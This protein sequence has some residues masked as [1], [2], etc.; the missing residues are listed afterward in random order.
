MAPRRLSSERQSHHQETSPMA[1]FLVAGDKGG[2][3][4]TT[5][6]LLLSFGLG[7]QDRNVLWLQQLDWEILE[8][9]FRGQPLPFR[10]ARPQIGDHETWLANTL[11]ATD[12]EGIDAVVDLPRDLE[13]DGRLIARTDLVLIPVRPGLM[14]RDIA[15]L[16]W[17]RYACLLGSAS[18]TRRCRLWLLPVAWPEGTDAV[19]SVRRWAGR[20][21]AQ[22]SAREPL[23][24]A[25]LLPD[26]VPWAIP[27]LP[28]PA[29][30]GLYRPSKRDH[31]LL[32]RAAETLA[33]VAVALAAGMGAEE[34]SR[35]VRDRDEQDASGG[36]PLVVE[37]TVS[38][39]ATWPDGT[40]VQVTLQTLGPLAHA[41]QPRRPRSGGARGRNARA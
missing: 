36:R 2:I 1:N 32:R 26:V 15:Y 11:A 20:I 37:G 30:D 21:H 27:R 7:W 18:G 12:A 35:I 29:L 6:S 9:H 23:P 17:R 28:E 40:R 39:H 22:R 24:D 25:A 41:A 19:A 8:I 31:P 38:G 3:G 34:L 10:L 5:S 16:T 4:R 33:E 14:E 13:P